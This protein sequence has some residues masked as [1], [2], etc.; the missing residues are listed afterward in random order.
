ME[1]ISPCKGTWRNDVIR[2]YGG[3]ARYDG[4]FT[5]FVDD[6]GRAEISGR[7]YCYAFGNSIISAQDG[8]TVYAYDNSVVYAHKGSTVINCGGNPKIIIT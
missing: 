8:A 4:Q 6:G 2:Q 5:V 7:I 1:E 3:Y